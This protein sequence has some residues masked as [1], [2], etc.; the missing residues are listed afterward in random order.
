MGYLTAQHVVGLPASI[1]TSFADE[2]MLS[3]NQA[4][5]PELRSDSVTH[6]WACSTSP[7]AEYIKAVYIYS[8]LCA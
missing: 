1:E 6:V 7:E 3:A 8:P 4:Q 5:S 2:V